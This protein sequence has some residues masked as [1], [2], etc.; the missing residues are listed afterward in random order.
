MV[1]NIL[2]FFYF[3]DGDFY[4]QGVH[5]ENNIN[6]EKYEINIKIVL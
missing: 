2:N 1:L 6:I 5:K 3:Y 4:L